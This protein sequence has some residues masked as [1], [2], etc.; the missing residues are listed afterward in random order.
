MRR[1]SDALAVAALVLT[2]AVALAGVPAAVLAADQVTGS[3]DLSL[4]APSNEVAPGTEVELPVYVSNEPRIQESGPDAY[5]DR[6][7]T[8][9]AVRLTPR[10]GGTPIE[11][12]TGTYPVGNVPEGTSGPVPVSLTIPEDTPPGTY[13]VPVRV[14]YSYAPRVDYGSGTDGPE[15]RYVDRGETRSIAV[16]VEDRA[17]FEVVDVASAARV[18]G[19]AP[20][21]VTVRNTGTAP[22]REASVRVQ[23]GDDEVA[24]GTAS[25]RSGAYAGAWEPGENRTFAFRAA[26]ASEAVARE[27][28]FSGTVTYV[29]GRGVER[30]SRPLTAGLRAHSEIT[31]SVRNVSADLAVAEPGTVSATVR[32][33][34]PVAVDDAVAVLRPAGALT[35]TDR[36][37][38]LGRLPAGASRAVEFDVTVGS[39]ASAGPRQL[40]VSVRYR[41]P[42]G[43][44]RA[45]DPLTPTVA[46]APERDWLRVTPQNATFG[47]D[48]DNRL[49][50]RVANTEDVPLSDLRARLETE[51]PF[52]SESRVAY[53][54]R[55]GPGEST[56]VAFGLTVSEDAVPTRSSVAVNVTAERPDGER[57][58]VDTYVVPVTV[59][60]ESGASDTTVLAA[61]ALLAVIAM[62]AGWWWLRRR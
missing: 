8:A 19:E 31:F 26:V 15:Y 9:R 1:R 20:V 59:A 37:V 10:D 43:T 53:V 38:A 58:A 12:N 44:L 41:D 46:V 42:Q 2:V 11:V 4:Q 49:V 56:T 6:V 3:P 18:G 21:S 7:T 52:S 61:G 35:A 40:N 54:E 55:L 45:S 27:Y 13:R 30:T 39:A 25:D 62:I 51:P 48:T 57:I 33:E 60:V 34:G 28:P 47:V 5:V 14:R 16:T 24:F 36:E 32:N 29:D 17:Q 23:S 50:V 22:A